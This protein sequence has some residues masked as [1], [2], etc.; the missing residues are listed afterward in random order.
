MIYTNHIQTV[1]NISS[2]IGMFDY[3]NFLAPVLTFT[4]LPLK[5]LQLLALVGATV[6]LSNLSRGLHA[7]LKS[8][9]SQYVESVI[10]ILYTSSFHLTCLHI[11]SAT[12]NN[13]DI[14]Y[15]QQSITS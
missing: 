15:S 8:C 9:T 12:E 6:L 3:L 1:V 2:K 5:V 11:L 13:R 7:S 14:I 10:I 4:H